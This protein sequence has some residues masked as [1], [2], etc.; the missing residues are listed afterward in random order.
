M[1]NSRIN[2]KLLLTNTTAL[3]AIVYRVIGAFLLTGILLIG[4][5]SAPCQRGIRIYFLSGHGPRES[6]WRYTS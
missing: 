2:H 3:S 5:D 4:S 1:N 6:G